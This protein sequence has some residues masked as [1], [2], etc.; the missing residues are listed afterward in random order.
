MCHHWGC[1]SIYWPLSYPFTSLGVTNERTDKLF[2]GPLC[3]EGNTNVENALKKFFEWKHF[4]KAKRIVI[5]NI[6][7]TLY[8]FI[9]KYQTVNSQKFIKRYIINNYEKLRQ[10]EVSL[11]EDKRFH[12]SSQQ[13][14]TQIIGY[15]KAAPQKSN[16]VVLK[17]Y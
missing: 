11:V 1:T 17:K 9:F 10:V 2:S 12:V 6:I 7:D 13:K 15:E 14:K 3:P 8:S 5:P 16:L 4:K